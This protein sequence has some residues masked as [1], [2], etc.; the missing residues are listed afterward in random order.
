MIFEWAPGG[1]L[2]GFGVQERG[3]GLRASD[4]M[5]KKWLIRSLLLALL[6]TLD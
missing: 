6:L 5:S 3:R 1:V 4:N 2:R